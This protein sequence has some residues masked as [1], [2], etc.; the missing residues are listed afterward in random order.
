MVL[1]DGS[2]GVS[3]IDIRYNY[4]TFNNEACAAT[5]EGPALSGGGILL[6]GASDSS[7]TWN[8]VRGNSGTE[9]NSGGIVLMSAASFTHGANPTGEHGEEQHRVRELP[10]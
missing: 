2:G 7:V 1:D 3:A 10:A 4:V 6:L 9:A 5:D 8:T